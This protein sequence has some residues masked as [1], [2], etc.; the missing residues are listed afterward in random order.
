MAPFFL[1]AA[2]TGTP[3][4]WP[5]LPFALLLLCMALGPAA[6][7]HF[8]EKHYAK[9]A[10]GLAALVAGWCVLARGD[11]ASVGHALAEWASFVCLIGSL[12]V[13]AG[14]ILIS[15]T[16]EATPAAN[17]GFLLVASILANVIGTTGASMVLLRPWLRMNRYRY[18]GYHTAFFIFL[19][20]NVGG[21]LTP[22]GDPPL[23][24]GYLQGVPFFWTTEHLWRPWMVLVLLLVGI[25][26]LIDWANF[27][28]ASAKVRAEQ[29]HQESWRFW[30]GINPLLLGVAIAAV[31]WPSPWREIALVGAALL[32]WW[33]T[34]ADIH[35]AN[36][37]SFAPVREVAW[38][39][40]GI[41]VTMI[42][43]LEYL[44]VR[45]AGGPST[46]TLAWYWSTGIFSAVLDNAPTYLAM[47]TS[48]V[49]SHVHPLTGHALAPGNPVDMARYVLVGRHELAAI[50]LGAVWFGAMTY[51][52][53]GPNLMVRALVE[54]SGLKAPHFL[55][56][57][58]R[59]SIP[60]LL[61][62]VAVVGFWFLN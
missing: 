12:Y 45:S 62:A 7:R 11:T 36:H 10:I 29:A 55:E 51:I 24:M 44:L 35:R 48:S 20:A 50:S 47:L 52:G 41:F 28:R 56:Y 60:I 9:I 27:R 46:S 31:F 19:V 40:L 6:F 8:W 38:L 4:V 22:I 17:A 33:R 21:T 15:V 5:M 23:F 14:G 30:C 49:H 13:I 57:I 39:F 32:S 43:V 42:P 18:T 59:Y 26:Y 61:P 25:F 16:G 3:P 58:Y 54:R 2:G 53:N 37:F 1:A 34:P